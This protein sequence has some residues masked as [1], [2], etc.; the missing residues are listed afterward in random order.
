MSEQKPDDRS[1]AERENDA[2]DRWSELYAEAVDM[3]D[4]LDVI[5][6]DVSRTEAAAGG[7]DDRLFEI[8]V[9]QSGA[10]DLMNGPLVQDGDAHLPIMEIVEAGRDD[11]RG[12]LID[13]ADDVVGTRE[14]LRDAQHDMELLEGEV[15]DLSVEVSAIR[16]DGGHIHPE[17]T[18]AEREEQEWMEERMDEAAHVD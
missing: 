18:D 9:Q 5:E 6:N 2:S 13:A 14:D 3:K 16:A 12:D 8:S 17:P 1:L 7:L 4:R 15:E 11:L 10:L